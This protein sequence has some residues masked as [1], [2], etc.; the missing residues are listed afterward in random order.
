[1]NRR[2][3]LHAFKAAQEV[4]NY[5]D[6]PVLQEEVDPQIYLARNWLPQPFHLVCSK[7]TVITLIS[8]AGDIDLRKSSVNSFKM[9]VGDI[10]YIPAGTPHAILPRNEGVWLRYM[11]LDAGYVGA[12]WFC[13]DCGAELFRYEWEHQNDVPPS[14]CYLKACEKFNA[15]D[16]QRT[17][18]KCAAVHG[19]VDV[20]PFE[21]EPS[22]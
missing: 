2:R 22:L 4:G 9:S 15:D 16:A 7:D 14:R 21:W 1:M 20:A 13:Q 17:C 10:A 18:G 3:M 5:A 12:A 6:V 19:P 11:P 8:G